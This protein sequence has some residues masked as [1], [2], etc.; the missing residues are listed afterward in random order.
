MLFDE[1]Q[2][3]SCPWGVDGEAA[4]RLGMFPLDFDFL[5]RGVPEYYANAGH[6]FLSAI[7][8]ITLPGAG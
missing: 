6:N 2:R 3:T 7:S 1:L 4:R 5:V 8:V